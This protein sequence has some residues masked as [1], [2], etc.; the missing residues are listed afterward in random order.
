VI[1]SADPSAMPSVPSVTMNDGMRAFVTR[2]P[3]NAPHA[4]PAAS[5]TAS[6]ASS[7]PRLSPPSAFIAFAA[8]TPEK[9]STAPTERSIPAVMMM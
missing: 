9:T 7:T 5:A 4:Q 2:K 1:S 8:T 3:L 6:P